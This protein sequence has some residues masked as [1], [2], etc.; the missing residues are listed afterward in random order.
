VLASKRRLVNK[1]KIKVDVVSDVV[2]PWCYIGKRRLEQAIL[3]VGHE[4][5]FEVRHFPFELNANIPVTGLNQKE[6]LS[7]RFGSQERFQQLTSHVTS[8]AKGEGLRFDF[9]RQEVMPNTLNAHRLIQLAAGKGVQDAVVEA[10]M[11]AYF[12]DGVDLSRNENLVDITSRAGLD[13]QEAAALLKSDADISMIREMETLSQ[14]RGVS[15]VPFFIINDQYGVSGA[16]PAET[17]ARI[18]REAGAGMPKQ[19]AASCEVDKQNC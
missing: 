4:I 15:G 7:S 9:E 19:E 8:V 16:Q 2:C 3:E 5:D 12:E 10:L 18:F 14:R 1:V 17:L 13:P 11:K 6:Y